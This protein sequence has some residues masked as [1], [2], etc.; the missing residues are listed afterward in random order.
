M[1]IRIPQSI[2]NPHRRAI[3]RN[4]RANILSTQST[5][6][7]EHLYENVELEGP[8]SVVAYN[9]CRFEGAHGINA[10]DGNRCMTETVKA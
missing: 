2:L 9:A 6:D 4:H 1:H 10:F 7:L 5:R 8:S 3:E